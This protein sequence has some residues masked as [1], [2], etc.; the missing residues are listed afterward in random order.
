M[1][2]FGLFGKKKKDEDFIYQEEN[3]YEKIKSGNE[4]EASEMYEP[5]DRELIEQAVVEERT[6]NKI[7][8]KKSYVDLYSPGGHGIL[9]SDKY[10]FRTFAGEGAERSR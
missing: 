9:K 6:N 7:D 2:F 3:L 4:Q 10:P 8:D 5:L 1:A